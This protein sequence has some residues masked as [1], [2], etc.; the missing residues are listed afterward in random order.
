MAKVYTQKFRVIGAGNFPFDMLRYDRCYPTQESQSRSF[1]SGE[2]RIVELEHAG[3]F[4]RDWSPTHGRWESFGWAVGAA[5]NG[6]RFRWECQLTGGWAPKMDQA[7][8]A[9]WDQKLID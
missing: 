9:D 1:D 2:L 8:R 3:E 5:Y 4:L 6:R 7:K